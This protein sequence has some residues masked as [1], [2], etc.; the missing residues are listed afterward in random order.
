MSVSDGGKRGKHRG[1]N[2][3]KGVFTANSNELLSIFAQEEKRENRNGSQKLEFVSCSPKVMF[4]ENPL[5][6]RE[7]GRCHFFVSRAREKGRERVLASGKKQVIDSDASL[8]ATKTLFF[9]CL[10]PQTHLADRANKHS[11]SKSPLSTRVPTPKDRCRA[12]PK[13]KAAVWNR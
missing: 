13:L 11:P 12:G 5:S 7:S 9:G 2:E 1:R 6:K 3:R 4:R 8:S 10:F